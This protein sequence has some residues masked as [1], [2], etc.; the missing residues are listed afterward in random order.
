MNAPRSGFYKAKSTGEIIQTQEGYHLPPDP[1]SN[2]AAE[3]EFV[4]E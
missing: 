1:K 3:W 2:D 4:G